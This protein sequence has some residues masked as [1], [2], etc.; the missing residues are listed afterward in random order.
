MT[1]YLLNSLIIPVDFSK[2]PAVWVRMKKA[3]IDEVRQLL[4][5]SEFVSAIGH[6]STAQLLSTVLGIPIPFNRISVKAIPG[7]TLIHFALQTRLPEGRVLSEEELRQ[8]DFYFVVSE[9]VSGE[10]SPPQRG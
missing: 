5:V 3:S 1:V 9:I 4:S 8:L 7:D 10:E 6:E 2:T